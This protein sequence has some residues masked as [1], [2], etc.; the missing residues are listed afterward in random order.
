M[1]EDTLCRGLNLEN[2]LG[3]TLPK[4]LNLS[5]LIKMYESYPQKEKFFNPFF[6]K[7]AGTN[8]LREQITKGLTEDEIRETWQ[9][10]LKEF[11]L[12]RKKYLLYK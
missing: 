11:M 10:G 2:A 7:L 1:Y 4:K 9:E 12:K 6:D 3:D 8:K 5:W